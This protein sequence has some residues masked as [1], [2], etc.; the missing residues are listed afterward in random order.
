MD[1]QIHIDRL[2]QARK[3]A[4]SQEYEAFEASLIALQDKLQMSD[5]S[6]LCQVF[7]DDTEDE[8]VMFGLVHFI[9]QFPRDEYLKCIA[10]CTPDMTDAHEWAMILNKRI[11]NCQEYFAQYT[12]IITALEKP[13]QTKIINLL[14]DVKGDHPDRFG[15]KVDHILEKARGAKCI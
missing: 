4:S 12:E 7:Y 9:E 15:E 6:K 5:I 1:N 13:D 2:F 10:M 3:L 14:M 11:L 8:E